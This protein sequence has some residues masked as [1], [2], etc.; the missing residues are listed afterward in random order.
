MDGLHA[1]AEAL[2]RAFEPLFGQELADPI[3]LCVT[4]SIGIALYP[5]HGLDFTALLRNADA[6]A[7]QA[8]AA[9]PA[10]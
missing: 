5:Q 9:G 2:R 1:A 6:A 4:A 7:Q 10:K 8:K 3:D